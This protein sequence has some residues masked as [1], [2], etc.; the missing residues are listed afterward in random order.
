MDPGA[1]GARR[2]SI[3]AHLPFH[4]VPLS[5]ALAPASVAFGTAPP[6]VRAR[7]TADGGGGVLLL[8]VVFVSE[9][10]RKTPE[11]GCRTSLEARRW[12]EPGLTA[13]AVPVMVSAARPRLCLGALMAA[14]NQHRSPT[15][16]I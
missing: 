12:R 10:W 8:R 11:N 14:I 13:R 15:D 4:C 16:R 7:C 5:G 9:R 6:P 3:N 1:D 2:R